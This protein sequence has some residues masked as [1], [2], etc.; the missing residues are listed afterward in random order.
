MFRLGVLVSSESPIQVGD[1]I[2]TAEGILADSDPTKH[3]FPLLE[4]QIL[5]D[6]PFLK[7]GL[8]LTFARDRLMLQVDGSDVHEQRRAICNLEMTK[9]TDPNRKFL[10]NLVGGTKMRIFM[11]WH[12]IARVYI[13]SDKSMLLGH[14]ALYIF[15]RQLLCSV[16]CDDFFL[17]PYPCFRRRSWL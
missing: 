5:A 12:S 17:V 11:D 7:A 16:Q 6:P 4:I 10:H 15:E 3:F 1:G 14:C 8:V 13:P 2:S 9:S